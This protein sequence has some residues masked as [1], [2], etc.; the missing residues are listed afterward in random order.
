MMTT[1]ESALVGLCTDALPVT[2]DSM[3]LLLFS[4]HSFIH[5]TRESLTCDSPVSHCS[6]LQLRTRVCAVTAMFRFFLYSNHQGNDLA[7]RS[8]INNECV[9]RTSSNLHARSPLAPRR[10]CHGVLLRRARCTWLKGDE[11][12]AEAH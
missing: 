2:D 11:A 10:P 7:T 5:H 4:L 6:A 1:R 8:F 3:L 12:L 9:K